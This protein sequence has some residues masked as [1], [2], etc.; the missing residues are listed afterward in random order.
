MTGL[1]LGL[2]AAPFMIVAMILRETG[3]VPEF[4]KAGADA[5]ERARRAA[6]LG[7][8]EGSPLRDA[9]RAGLLVATGDGRYWVDRAKWKRRRRTLWAASIAILA[10]GAGLGAWVLIEMM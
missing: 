8:E 4:L 6:S 7:V 5:P 10:T 3:P 1:K 9:V 2:V